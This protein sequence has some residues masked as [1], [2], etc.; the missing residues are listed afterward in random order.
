MDPTFYGDVPQEYSVNNK[1]V[2]TNSKNKEELAKN[3]KKA[4]ERSKVDLANICAIELLTSGVGGYNILWDTLFEV[5]IE[6]FMVL[7]VPKLLDVVL[8]EYHL[9]N[10]IKARHGHNQ[11]MYNNQEMRNHIAYV[12][13]LLS[14]CPKNHYNIKCKQH[15]EWKNIKEADKQ[16][17]RSSAKKYM[18][19]YTAK[20]SY[21][22]TIIDDIA[23]FLYYVKAKPILCTEIISSMIKKTA[24]I[25]IKANNSNEFIKH[26]PKSMSRNL[27]WILWFIID[28]LKKGQGKSSTELN[29]LI[30]GLQTLYVIM[31]KRKKYD[32]ATLTIITAIMAIKY[33]NDIMWDA[34]VPL[35]S[36]IL[37]RLVTTINILYKNVC[38][39]KRFAKSALAELDK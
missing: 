27:S 5:L 30:R 21:D 39:N 9:T 37:L 25:P 29:N 32:Y 11:E 18:S 23:K 3:L 26:I 10:G 38:G 16:E 7:L 28:D 24:Q 34:E 15:S 19:K 6:N 2:K 20:R 31:Y 33:Q 4:I 12:V 17:L 35:Q 13:T 14:L 8:D 36:P 22:S 1:G